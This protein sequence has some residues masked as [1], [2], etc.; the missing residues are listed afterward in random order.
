VAG[1][2]LG[3][4]IARR[5]DPARVRSTFAIFVLAMA[6]LIIVREIDTWRS[7][8]Q[9]ALPASLPQLIFALAVL[10]LGVAA[11]RFT[12]SGGRHV[13]DRGHEGGSGI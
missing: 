5:V 11:G 1:S 6:A 7:T 8:A 12:R 13:L 4:R 10:S 9:S 2:W 3:A